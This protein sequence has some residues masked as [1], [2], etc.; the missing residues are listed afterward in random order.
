MPWHRGWSLRSGVSCPETRHSPA[1]T[2][3]QFALFFN[4]QVMGARLGWGLITKNEGSPH[5]LKTI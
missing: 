5:A 1:P 4:S 2:V 3:T